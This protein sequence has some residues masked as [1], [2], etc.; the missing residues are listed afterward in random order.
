MEVVKKNEKIRRKLYSTLDIQKA[1][2]AVNYGMSVRKAAKKFVVPTTPVHRAVKNP[3]KTNFETGHPSVYRA[4]KGY[5]VTKVQLLDSVQKYILDLGNKISKTPFTEKRPGRHWYENFR[6][7]HPQIT[8][9]T[10]QNLSM[11][12]ASV[13]EEDLRGWFSKIQVY[14]Q[15]KGLH[16]LQP[17]R[18][19]NCDETNVQLIPK[20][21]KVL[22][23]KGATLVY[24]VV[25][26]CETESLTAL[27]THSADGTRAPP[28]L[29]FKHADSVPASILKNCPSDWSF[30]NSKNGWMTTK[31]FY[32][33]IANVFYPWL[34]KSEIEFPVIIY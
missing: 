3:E 14:L 12:P 5:P 1:V 19:F 24:I 28:R 26:R 9:R 31:T 21:E 4:E 17:S 20:S 32:E 13:T 33:Y 16:K 29:M 34:Q 23:E 25:N 18:V 7:R 22:S 10:L 11:A 2:S 6:V 8:T 15:L 30:S 27:F